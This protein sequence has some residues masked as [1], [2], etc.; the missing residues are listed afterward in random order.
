MPTLLLAA[1]SQQRSH[2]V[3]LRVTR[4]GVA[5]GGADYY[6]DHARRGKREPRP[7]VLFRDQRREPAVFGERADEFFGIAVRLER[8]PVFTGKFPAELSYCVPDVH[9][10][11]GQ[12][13][14]HR[15]FGSHSEC[16]LTG[17]APSALML[18]MDDR[19]PCGMSR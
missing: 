17:M 8:A 14:V 18:S 7:P 3:H 15:F 2:D 1:V 5:A 4:A 13:E 10:L 9:Q 12:R 16:G 6:K 11:V 19:S